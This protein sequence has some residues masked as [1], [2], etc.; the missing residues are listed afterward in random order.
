MRTVILLFRYRRE[1]FDKGHVFVAVPPLY[2]VEAGKKRQWCF[3]DEEL[4]QY[5]GKLQPGSYSIQRFK[6]LGEMMPDQLWDTT[7][8]PATRLLRRLTV[9][10]ASE[11]SHMFSLLMGDNVAPRRALIEAHGSKYVQQGLDV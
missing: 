5:V 2:K 9:D 6:G 8:N 10:D 11:A 4:K 1:L 3:T 7:M